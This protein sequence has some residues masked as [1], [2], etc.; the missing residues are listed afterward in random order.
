[1]GCIVARL[2]SNQVDTT[3]HGFKSLIKTPWVDVDSYQYSV[4]VT[5]CEDNLPN[6]YI[7]TWIDRKTC[8]QLF[9][10]LEDLWF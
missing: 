1:M 10:K 6:V 3:G 4:N 5:T 8:V 2:L 9:F 7:K